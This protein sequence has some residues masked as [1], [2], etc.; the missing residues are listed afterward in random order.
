MFTYASILPR[1]EKLSDK[2]SKPLLFRIKIQKEN[3]R[4]WR[5][6]RDPSRQ[7]DV[8]YTGFLL[9]AVGFYKC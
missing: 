3:V 4:K 1:N 8:A 6:A 9:E 5:K 2:K 7:R